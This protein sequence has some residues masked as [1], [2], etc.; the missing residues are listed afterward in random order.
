MWQNRFVWEAKRAIN[1]ARTGT[2]LKPLQEWNVLGMIDEIE[3]L[4]LDLN[5]GCGISQYFN[6][7]TFFKVVLA[8]S[9]IGRLARE[10]PVRRRIADEGI[11]ERL[12]KL[13][14]QRSHVL[15]SSAKETRRDPACELA[16]EALLREEAVKIR[17]I[18]VEAQDAAATRSVWII[19][20]EIEQ[21]GVGI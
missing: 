10:L 11:G 15:E 7:I 16:D 6:R 4:F 9:R 2:H 3:V 19:L 20:I 13:M 14:A 18:G 5:R 8:H 12:R 17:E 1:C 21:E